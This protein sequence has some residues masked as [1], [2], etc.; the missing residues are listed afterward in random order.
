MYCLAKNPE[1]Q[2]KAYEEI[3]EVLKDDEPITGEH[4]TRMP[5]LKACVKES[6]RLLSKFSATLSRSSLYVNVQCTMCDVPQYLMK[7]LHKVI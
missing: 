6:Q 7:Q 4:I 5:Y 1:V 3:Q 2:Q